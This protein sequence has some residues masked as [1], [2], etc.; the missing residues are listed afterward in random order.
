MT[1]PTRY[2][3]DH[4]QECITGA[5]P[6]D[7]TEDPD[8]GWIKHKDHLKQ[9]TILMDEMNQLMDKLKEADN[10]IKFLVTQRSNLI[11]KVKELEGAEK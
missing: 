10:T 5:L 11:D 1:E 8:G 7:M 9:V 4:G 3:T 6:V 2:K